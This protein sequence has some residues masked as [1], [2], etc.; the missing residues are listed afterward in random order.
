MLNRSF[1]HHR[2]VFVTGHTGFKGGWLSLWLHAMGAKVTG[3]ALEPPTE[4]SLF[5]QARVGEYVNSIHGDVRDFARLKSA[6]AEC[7]PDVILHMAA[8]SVVRYGYEEPVETYATNVMGTVHLL[9]AVR[10]LKR[11]RVVVNVTSDKCYA[12]HEWIW[13]YRES[14]A[15]GGHDPY[16]NSKGCA[17]LV[18]DAYRDSYFSANAMSH[19]GVALGSARA[20]NVIGGGDWTANQL[21]PDLIRA[22]LDRRPC[23]IRNPAAIRPWQF[24]L[25]PLHGYLLLCEKLAEEGSPF[26]SG[27]NFGPAQS[28]ARPVSWIADALASSWGDGAS[29]M[30]DA[31]KHPSEAQLLRLDTSKATAGLNWRPALPLAEGL[32]WIVEWYQAFSAGDDLQFITRR[33]IERYEELLDDQDGHKSAGLGDRVARIPLHSTGHG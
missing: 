7:D 9:E 33:Q 28:D 30:R 3:Y 24:V 4:P 20:G 12:N 6:I 8:Q 14:D 5:E 18:T 2:S 10:Q 1:W 27:W 19:S 16:S 25:E 13:G 29:W 23:R 26:A 17:E 22:F 11:P 15:M 21:I 31:G 32:D